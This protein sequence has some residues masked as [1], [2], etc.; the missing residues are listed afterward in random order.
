MRWFGGPFGGP[1]AGSA[2]LGRTGDRPAAGALFG[3]LTKGHR[4]SGRGQPSARPLSGPYQALM[5]REERLLARAQPWSHDEVTLAFPIAGVE[6]AV[7]N[8][9]TACGW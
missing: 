4:A 6:Q 2:D 5:R 3:R 8:V 9:R 7:A 1:L